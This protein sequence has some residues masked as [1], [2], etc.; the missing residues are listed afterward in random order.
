MTSAGASMGGLTAVW[1]AHCLSFQARQIAALSFWSSQLG[2][3]TK[4]WT[5]T[6]RRSQ[7][8]SVTEIDFGDL[9]RYR[10]FCSKRGTSRGGS[11]TRYYID[12]FVKV[13]LGPT[14]GR[15]LECGD[16][17]Y[18][19]FLDPSRTL[20][21]DCLDIDENVPGVT[22]RADLNDLHQIPDD[23]YDVVIC[24]QVFQYLANPVCAA[25]EIRRVLVPG[26]KLI[27]TVPFIER[28]FRRLGDKTRFTVESLRQLLGAFSLVSVETGGNLLTSIS[29]LLGL[30]V[31]DLSE[32]ELLT[33]DNEY[34][35]VTL[36]SA[37]K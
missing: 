36:G 5:L 1:G 35:Q 20:A 7:N 22:I 30:G 2:G 14:R 26:G 12:R 16:T 29:S 4:L 9:R 8:V 32:E 17:R 3:H 24:T 23:S 27:L 37:V 25:S 13:E 18:F 33:T 28:D 19:A 21:Y 34:Y 10:P 31:A 11:I 15:Y 6:L